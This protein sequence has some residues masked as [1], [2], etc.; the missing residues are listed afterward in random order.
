MASRK[1]LEGIAFRLN[2]KLVPFEQF[3]LHLNRPDIIAERIGKSSPQLIRAYYYLYK[4]RLKKL[5]LEEGDLKLDYKLPYLQIDSKP[6]IVTTD[7]ESKIW[8][9]AWDDNYNLKQLNVYV[10]NV[11]LFGAAGYTIEGN[12]KSIRKEVTIPLIN[13]KNKILL[14]VLNSNGVESLYE[15]VEIVR[16]GIPEKHDLYMVSIG[17]S[18][19]KDD[20]FNLKYPTKDAQDM[21][22][23]FKES[24]LR[25]RNV[26]Q[27][28]LINEEVTLENI[29][30]LKAFFA[31]CTHEDLAIIFIAGHGVLDQ[32]YNYYFG[33]Y[34]MDFNQPEDRGLAY[35]ELSALL[36]Q[37]K[38]YQK[39][40]IMD[41][42]HS[43]ELDK[44]EIEKG[45]PAELEEGDVQ[46]RAAGSGVRKKDGLGF[47]NSVKF[48][49]DLFSD[50]RR[51]SGATVI[52]SAG[53]AEFAMESDEWNNGLFTYVFLRGLKVEND[54]NKVYLSEIREYV[55]QGVQKLSKGKQIP[56][57]REENISRD[58]IIFGN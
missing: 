51:G 29:S 7:K 30:A 25:Y 38:A 57:A 18:D 17:V 11:P 2:G 44:D 27:K 16:D 14:S 45:P 52:S 10:N 1:A 41:T 9:K 46:F 31:N 32:D 5:N 28:R 12:V 23:K 36:N 8:I 48:T 26:Y 33:T 21:L 35:A 54:D 39:L 15:T 6:D 24:E 40:L 58:Y 43:G 4:K 19:Y 42:C 13:G 22:N 3:D 49:Q 20:R 50:L 34:D 55:N 47:N 53:G 56:T 37:I